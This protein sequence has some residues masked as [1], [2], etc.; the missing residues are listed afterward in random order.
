MFF[1][2]CIVIQLCNVNIVLQLCNVNIVM[3]LRNANQ[4]NARLKLMF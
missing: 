4:Q 1:V 2:P 3:Q